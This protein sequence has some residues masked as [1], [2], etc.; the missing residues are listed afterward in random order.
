MK[1]YIAGK[2]TGEPL[3]A[4]KAKFAAAEQ[5]LIGAGATPINPFN[6]G[7][8]DHWTFDQCKST[9]FEAIENCTA[10]YMLNDWE[11][12]PGSRVELHEA[13]RL[14]HDVFQEVN[15]DI[16]QINALVK[17]GLVG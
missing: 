13:M 10:I 8:P 15:K 3:E 2:I 1:I 11:S 16:K 5:Q 6:L 9:C 14:R 12:S 17:V 4:C 7:C